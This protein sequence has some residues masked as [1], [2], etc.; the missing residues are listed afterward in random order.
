MNFA[1][2]TQRFKI[3]SDVSSYWMA[4]RKRGDYGN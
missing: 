2:V 4:F 1:V 3:P